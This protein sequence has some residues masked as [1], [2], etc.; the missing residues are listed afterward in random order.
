VSTYFTTVAVWWAVCES[1]T[2]PMDYESTALTN[3]S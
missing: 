2:A 1:N 3:M